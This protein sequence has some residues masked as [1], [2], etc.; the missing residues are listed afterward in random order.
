MKANA[1]IS[2]VN[3]G[4]M[5]LSAVL[6]LLFPFELF[7][8][9]I[10]V[11]GPLHYLTEISWLEKRNFFS[12]SKWN[13]AVLAVLAI[14]LMLP[15]IDKKSGMVPYQIPAIMGAFAYAIGLIRHKSLWV[16]LAY[17]FGVF[18]AA[19]YFDLAANYSFVILFGVFLPTI[20]HVLVFTGLFLLSGALKN[21]T[22][23]EYASV[24]VFIGCILL[25]MLPQYSF[26]HYAVSDKAKELYIL[27]LATLNAALVKAFG[28]GTFTQVS[29]VFVGQGPLKVMSLI[30]FA[31]TY[32][33][34]NW[35]SKTSVIK[36]HEVSKVRL[37]F[38]TGIWVFVVALCMMDYKTGF[39]ILS[40]M[41]LLHVALEFP[42]NIRSMG[43]IGRAFWPRAV[44]G[45]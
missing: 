18:F 2:Y 38:I 45:G 32:H 30:A 27:P 3:I 28:W 11:L 36:W 23:P 33:Y 14:L 5:V 41:S 44:K 8:F 13:V 35:F 34:F 43:D 17:F 6:A 20:I 29:D 7:L 37:S 39:L 40:F 9:S 42:L 31:Y 10:I 12:I 1:T 25:I 16:N 4:L 26:A 19:V 21:K 22:W 24:L 15:S